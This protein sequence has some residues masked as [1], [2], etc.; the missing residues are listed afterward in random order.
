MYN[1]IDTSK[2]SRRKQYEWFRTFPN[3]CYGFDCT[4][5]VTGVVLYSKQTNTSFFINFLY[6][7][8][9][10][11]NE[12]EEMRLRIVDGTVRLYDVIDPTYTIMTDS[13]VYENSGSPMYDDYLDFYKEAKKTIESVKHNK[14]IKDT[15]NSDSEYGVYYITCIPWISYNSMTHPIPSGNENSLSV[16]R[17]CW[18]KFKLVDNKYTMNLNITVSHALVDGFALSRAFQ[19]VQ[20][21]LDE[22]DK[23]LK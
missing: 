3:P 11:L 16:P 10:A 13:L 22:C 17:I 18:D 12:I 4:I 8:M 9:K 20:T 1:I 5:D 19:N 14:K 7:L 2:W 6:I 21:K 23:I 15:Y